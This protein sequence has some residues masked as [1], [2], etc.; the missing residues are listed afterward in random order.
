MFPE[1]LSRRAAALLSDC[2]SAGTRLATAESCTA[3]LVSALLT[4]AAG[5]SDVFDRG[6]VTYS[7]AAKSELLGI[8][9]EALARHGA[10]SAE[11][12]RAMAAGALARS[13]ADVAVSVT[14]IAGPGGGSV[15]KPVGL[16]WFALARRGCEPRA[17]ERRF[18][19]LGR[20]GVRI[21]SVEEALRLFEEA[22]GAAG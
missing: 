4:E 13:R 20:G 6:F 1:D 17:V 2:R 3:G 10:V 9:G 19:D 15:E 8:P 12:A 5:A 7:N 16:V 18:G 14:G 22:V 21:A 11:T